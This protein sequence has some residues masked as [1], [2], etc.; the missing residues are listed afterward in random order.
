MLSVFLGGTCNKST[1]RDELITKLDSSK[2]NAFNPVVPNWTEEA[3]LN[4]LNHRK[5]DDICLYVLTPEI[6]PYNSISDAEVVDDSNK[7]PKQTIF[8]IIEE[9]AGKRFN[10]HQQKGISML[11][12]ILNQNG[13]IIFNDLDQV[14]EYLN[15]LA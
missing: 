4:E 15:N 1:W 8:C 14:A 9:R 12:K 13:V 10:E 3:Q 7:R 2:I 11:N 6:P 5:N